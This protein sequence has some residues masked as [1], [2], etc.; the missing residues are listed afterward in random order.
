MSAFSNDRSISRAAAQIFSA[1]SAIEGEIVVIPESFSAKLFTAIFRA[2]L[3]REFIFSMRCNPV[4]K[5]EQ[6]QRSDQCSPANAK[7]HSIH[8]YQ[9]L[10]ICFRGRN[11]A[12]LMLS[13]SWFLLNCDRI[14]TVIPC[15]CEGELSFSYS[16][17]IH[18]L[19][20]VLKTTLRSIRG[21]SIR[22]ASVDNSSLSTRRSRGKIRTDAD[23]NATHRVL[24]VYD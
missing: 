7:R 14:F 2:L 3:E 6:K 23:A 9:Q 20:C 16:P 1:E 18:T 15:R 24:C 5:T 11:S 8:E 21:T 4:P 17:V 13:G 19:K 12:L 22:G 10:T